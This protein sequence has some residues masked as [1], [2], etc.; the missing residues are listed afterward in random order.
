MRAL[1]VSGGSGGHLTP[2]IAVE[3]ALKEIDPKTTSFFLCSAKPSDAVYLKHEKVAFTTAPLPKKNVMLP[4]TW[5]RNARIAK[6]VLRDF[7]PDVIFSKGGA[8][9]VPLCRIAH[10]K[11]IPIVI[12]ESDSVMGKANKM[13]APLATAICVG[14]PP[15]DEQR[16]KGPAP[17]VTGNPIRKAMTKGS[18]KR[19]YD[20]AHFTGKHPVLLV[21][22]GSQ[23][24]E[25]VNNAI[26]L[27]IKELLP[28]CD[29][30]HITG[31]GKGGAKR[32]AG[33]WSKEFV[34][35]ELADLYAIA[36]LALC[37]AGAGTISECVANEIPMVLVPIRGL[38]NDHQYEN[39]V[40]AKAKGA[41][42]IL[43][44]IHLE[45]DLPSVIQSLLGKSS[46]NFASMK[47]A[48]AQL[49]QPEAARRIAKILLQCVASRTKRH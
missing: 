49:R 26:R 13:I 43:E 35:D 37:R 11:K 48:T 16:E 42:V 29:V 30:V 38:A 9:S 44:Q 10:K 46:K 6:R 18:K 21:Y 31:P 7:K 32:Q 14:F 3:R 41:A 17:I 27:H 34:Y 45:H 24:A 23:G 40:R 4:V 5:M 19:G 15:S 36:D 12:H 22:G 39:A 8:V 1:F 2:L 33:Y 25:A 28:F 20:L 47:A